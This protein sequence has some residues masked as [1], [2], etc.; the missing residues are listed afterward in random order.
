MFLSL[1]F[2]FCLHP[3]VVGE[4]DVN[5]SFLILLFALIFYRQEVQLP[6]IWIISCIVFYLL[7]FFPTIFVFSDFAFVLE[8]RMISLFAFLA[9]FAFCFVNFDKKYQTAFEWGLILFGLY[10]VI[11][12]FSLY[13]IYLVAPILDMKDFV[14]SQLSGVV[15]IKIASK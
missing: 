13:L 9:M 15:L 3:I 1:F 11:G 2:A 10:N 4:L 8:R 12:S 6:D 14:G 7:I 5:F